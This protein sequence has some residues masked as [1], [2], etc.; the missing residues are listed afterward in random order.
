MESDNL[1]SA[2]PVSLP[3]IICIVLPHASFKIPGIFL[4]ATGAARFQ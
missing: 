3:V 2:Q 1:I 4:V